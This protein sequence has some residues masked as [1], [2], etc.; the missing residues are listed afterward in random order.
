MLKTGMKCGSEAKRTAHPRFGA[1]KTPWDLEK[2]RRKGASNCR[3]CLSRRAARLPEAQIASAG[4]DPRTLLEAIG[5][6]C[7]VG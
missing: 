4:M 2:Q 7:K 3:S 5:G 1:A 6:L